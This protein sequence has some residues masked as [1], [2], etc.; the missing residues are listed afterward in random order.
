MN[1][2]E[3]SYQLWTEEMNI[4]CDGSYS[5]QTGIGV[6]VYVSLTTQEVDEWVELP[7]KEIR[8]KLKPRVSI[9]CTKEFLGS[10]G[11]EKHTLQSAL[12]CIKD[13]I[14]IYTDCQK[15]CQDYDLAV[16][17]PGHS[18]GTNRVGPSKIFDGVDKL[19]RKELRR[20]VK[21]TV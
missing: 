19:A 14:A 3:W 11:V 21:S 17:I 1:L 5:P 18:K 8:T 4:F 7:L 20:V 12:R 6:G 10:S 2:G 15:I 16:K 9:C 13:V